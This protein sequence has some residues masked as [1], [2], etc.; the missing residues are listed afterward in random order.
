MHSGESLEERRE[1]GSK[2]GVE[3]STGAAPPPPSP[4]ATLKATSEVM[5]R[6]SRE[7]VGYESGTSINRQ[8]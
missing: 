4:E 7:E 1:L 8:C 3:G 6:S 5:T 2:N